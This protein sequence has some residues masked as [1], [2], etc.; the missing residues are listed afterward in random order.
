MGSIHIL[1]NRVITNLGRTLGRTERPRK[2]L[3]EKTA[4]ELYLKG[5]YYLDIQRG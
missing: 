2:D 3:R 4:F 1:G 5:G